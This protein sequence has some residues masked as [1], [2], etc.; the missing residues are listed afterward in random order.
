MREVARA[1]V[2]AAL[3]APAVAHAQGTTRDSLNAQ[4]VDREIK[5]RVEAK[6]ITFAVDNREDY[7]ELASGELL[8]ALHAVQVTA[9]RL[10]P[11]EVQFSV[12]RDEASDPAHDALVRLIGGLLQLP[13]IFNPDAAANLQMSESTRAALREAERTEPTCAALSAAG[14]I[15]EG[16]HANL[17]PG[18]VSA[19]R[20]K[21]D[22]A[23]WRTVIANRPGAVGVRES[24]GRIGK[25]VEELKGNLDAALAAILALEAKLSRGELSPSPRTCETTARLLLEDARLTNPRARL[26]DLKR[27]VATLEGIEKALE[28]Y[29]DDSHWLGDNYILYA[30][31]RPTSD[32]MQK[33]TVKGVRISFVPTPT[34]LDV[35]KEDAAS[36]EFS[37]RT[38][39]RFT[40]EIGAGL[41]LSDV[42]RPK[43]GTTKNAA[44]ETV[45][46]AAKNEAE[47]YDAAIVT[48]FVCRCGWGEELTPMIQLGVAPRPSSPSIL[49]G[50]G[51][52]LFGLGKGDVAVGVG[53]IMAWVKDLTDLKPGDAVS[54]TK[55]IE[56]DLSYQRRTRPYVALLYKF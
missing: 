40:P 3:F 30:E 25:R 5:V 44:G 7:H 54:G 48:N 41:I 14:T 29:A 18:A 16:L 22:F 51:V 33:V 10:N 52:R 53:V 32:K 19:D 9:P 47:S 26:N 13:G 56:A 12:S 2:M 24:S 27:I 39:R 20:L 6:T 34:G 8:V 36:G 11:L 37:V 17:F 46:G 23:D 50:A 38:F 49:L 45:I 35:A 43:Y 42:R 4:I 15:I 21:N 28:P 1:V 55:D 31:L